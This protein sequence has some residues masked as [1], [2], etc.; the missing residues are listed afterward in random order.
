VRL[1][2]AP[3]HHHHRD[4]CYGSDDKGSREGPGESVDERRR[5]GA[6]GIS[7]GSHAPAAGHSRGHGQGLG[8]RLRARLRSDAL[9]LAGG[10]HGRREE[11]VHTCWVREDGLHGKEDDAIGRGREGGE[12]RR[13][14]VDSD[15][16][17]ELSGTGGALEE[18]R[19]GGVMGGGGGRGGDSRRGGGG[20]HGRALMARGDK[21]TETR[22]GGTGRRRSIR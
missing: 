15:L 1:R 7:A 14:D 10:Q 11:R 16:D 8:W 9:G 21:N 17:A 3:L 19:G 6:G 18:T 4:G 22:D 13:G 20:R 2:G 12:G 5:R